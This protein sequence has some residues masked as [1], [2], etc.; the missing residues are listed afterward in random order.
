MSDVNQT[1]MIEEYARLYA[2]S[3][4][5]YGVDISGKYDSA[6]K[7]NM[8][9]HEAYCRGIQDGFD[10][11]YESKQ[12]SNECGHDC[13][14]CWK[15]ELVNEQQWISCSER[16]PKDEKMLYWTTH[17]DESVV[18]H[19]WSKRHG[20]IYNWEVDDLEKRKRMG[21]VVAWI[22]IFEPEPY[23]GK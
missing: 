7:M 5:L 10:K 21:Q 4:L 9:L 23:E 13:K 14:S 19:G 2:E 22:P 18:L 1:K 16:L 12:K 6:V 15:T 20:F 8:V 11:A 17:E 3:L